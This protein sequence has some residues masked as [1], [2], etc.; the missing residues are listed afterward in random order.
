MGGS[1]PMGPGGAM[2][3]GLGYYAYAD[4]IEGDNPTLARELRERLDAE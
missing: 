2:K 1:R 3:D 4:S